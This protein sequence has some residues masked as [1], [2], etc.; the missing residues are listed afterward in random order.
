MVDIFTFTLYV[1]KRSI[2]MRC[3]HSLLNQSIQ[4][5]SYLYQG[6]TVQAD[7]T[8]IILGGIPAKPS[9][10]NNSGRRSKSI[11]MPVITFLSCSVVQRTIM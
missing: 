8:P 4:G 9:T 5:F 6:T 3:C 1:E 2:C 7:A 10:K 11:G